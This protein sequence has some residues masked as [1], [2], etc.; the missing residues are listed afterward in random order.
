MLDLE[1]KSPFTVVVVVCLV[2]II[3]TQTTSNTEAQFIMLP[4][5]AKVVRVT[6]KRSNGLHRRG[7]SDS[8]YE[9]VFS[10]ASQSD[11]NINREYYV[12]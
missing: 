11:I 7:K 5:V 8:E 10:T 1:G 2:T 3:L 6:I 4:Y 9:N 12:K